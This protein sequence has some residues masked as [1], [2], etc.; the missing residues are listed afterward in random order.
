MTYSIVARDP[1][2]GRFGIG[3]QS[4]YLGVGPVVPWLEAGVGAVATQA[5]VNT[6]FGPI[7]LELLRAGRSA[8]EVVA[9]LV[10][11][12][13]QAEVRQVGVVDA[14]GQAAAHT[15]ADCIPAAGHLARDGFSVQ[16]NL[17]ER[18]SCWPAMATAYEE[19]LA[20]GEPLVERVLRA[21][22]AA[23]REGGDVRGKQSAALMIVD[24]EL[25]PAAWRGRL[26]DMRIEDHPDPVPELRR[27]VSMQL[28]Y[29]LLNDEGEAAR[30]GATA[31]ERYARA[32]VLSPDAYELVFWR[33]VELA[34]AGELDAA[35]REL[36]I[37]FAADRRWRTTLE[38]MASAGREGVTPELA[39]QLLAEA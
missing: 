2:T 16:G 36:S 12:D 15:G 34:V 3:V 33:G 39:A 22:E 29:D 14:R 10:A 4:H 23:E 13:S 19:A 21:M 30:G 7:G 38:H 26:M 24:A 27:I 6:S 1:Q 20:A 17:L 31:E 37:A 35:R 9:A 18:D 25:Q 32:R 11:S 5:S 8:S 28:A